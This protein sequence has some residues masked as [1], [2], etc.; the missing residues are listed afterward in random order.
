[1]SK[2]QSTDIVEIVEENK[3][4]TIAPLQD[5]IDTDNYIKLSDEG[6]ARINGAFNDIPYVLKMLYDT[7]QFSGTYKVVYDKGLGVLQR[8]A[9]DPNL[10]R[11][12]VVTPGTN[13]DIKT[14]A[15]LQEID[16]SAVTEVSNIAISAFTVASIVT[17]QYFLARIDKKLGA[18]ENKVAEVLQFAETD[19]KSKLLAN[20]EILKEYLCDID[21]IQRDELYHQATITRV[22]QIRNESLENINFYYDQ[23]NSKLPFLK[24][25]KNIKKDKVKDVTTKVGD[26]QK[27]LSYYSFSFY[28]Y[29]LSYYIEAL[30]RNPDE[31]VLGK[32]KNTML[33]KIDEFQDRANSFK[34]ELT[35]YVDYVP[36]LNPTILPAKAM[37]GIGS[38]LLDTDRRE[39]PV[40]TPVAENLGIIIGGGGL[41]IE[42]LSTASEE[43]LKE[44]LFASITSSTELLSCTDSIKEAISSLDYL[45]DMQTNR[46]E[47][48]ISEDAA[49]LKIDTPTMGEKE[50]R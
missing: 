39:I 32:I 6:F 34:K 17:N 15:L 22:Q 45:T 16:P 19:K 44:N 30:M 43:N 23:L 25:K 41:V 1:M 38:F 27:L 8:S 46:V 48:V 31:M 40:I 47:F 29:E 50:A 12:N 14:Q 35:T 10:F 28:L 26:F 9:Q 21:N 24:G 36:V 7:N 4:I 5:V 13:N 20:E 11:A 37:Q 49:Y 42:A 33:K 2:F 3:G 18:L